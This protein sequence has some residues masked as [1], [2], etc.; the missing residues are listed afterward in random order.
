MMGSGRRGA[1]IEGPWTVE[2]GWKEEVLRVV[3]PYRR[4]CWVVVIGKKLGDFA[5][6]REGELF[7]G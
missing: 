2:E 7:S 5:V 1:K 6:R 4:S 3:E